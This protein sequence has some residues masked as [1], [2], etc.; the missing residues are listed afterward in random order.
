M[1]FNIRLLENLNISD[2][3]KVEYQNI[4]KSCEYLLPLVE[5]II[6]NIKSQLDTTKYTNK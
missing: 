1:H 2:E 3:I 5:K 4:K 6:N